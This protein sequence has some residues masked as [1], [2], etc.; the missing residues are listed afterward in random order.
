[1]VHPDQRRFFSTAG[2]SLRSAIAPADR[3]PWRR[4]GGDIALKAARRAGR[5]CFPFIGVSSAPLH[6][7][8]AATVAAARGPLLLANVALP[9]GAIAGLSA[10]SLP[11][12]RSALSEEVA[13]EMAEAV[14]EGVSARVALDEARVWRGSSLA[15]AVWLP[16]PA[17]LILPTYP[18]ATLNALRQ[19]SASQAHATMQLSMQ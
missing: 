10:T 4:G 13:D 17:P 9:Q 5:G 11:A 16:V 7:V 15:A 14:A 8:C 19:G 1:M 2:A 6:G 18:H 12:S 3:A